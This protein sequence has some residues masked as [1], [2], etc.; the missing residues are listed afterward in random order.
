MDHSHSKLE[1]T[2]QSGKTQVDAR[3]TAILDG[4]EVLFLQKG[5]ENTRIIDIAAK[6]GISKM[7]LY[8]YFPN[9][10]VIALEIHARMLEKI[11]ALVGPG[12]LVLSLEKARELAVQM[13]RSFPELRE[14]YRFMGMFDHLY[15]DIPADSD[16]SKQTQSWLRSL[17]M[18]GN[19]LDEIS[20]DPIHDSRIIMVLS[21]V[22]WFLEKLALRGELTWSDKD[23]PLDE[24]LNMF[25]EMI[26]GYI[27]RFI[28]P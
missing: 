12:D 17:Q 9:R 18:G 1:T 22:I 14:A 3:R 4:A 6:A 7:S 28:E 8:R 27:D 21:T 15:L 10:D 2:R 20:P 19:R 11:S 25:E 13:I 5:L 23:V 16:L 26:T 24:H